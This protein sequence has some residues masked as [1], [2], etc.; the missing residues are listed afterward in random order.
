MGRRLKTT[1]MGPFDYQHDDEYRSKSRS[2]RNIYFLSRVFYR[3]G[4]VICGA[5]GETHLKTRSK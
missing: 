3:T 1:K 2:H 5:K 4:T